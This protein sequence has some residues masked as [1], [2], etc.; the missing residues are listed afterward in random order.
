MVLLLLG[1][2]CCFLSTSFLLFPRVFAK[3]YTLGSAL[4]LAST[5]FLMGPMAQ[6]RAMMAPQRACA[7]IT[8]ILSIVLTLYFAIG[9]RVGPSTAA[10]ARTHVP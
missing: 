7:S 1:L 5:F 2:A 3:W 10:Y 8:Y 6:L 4:I 9:V